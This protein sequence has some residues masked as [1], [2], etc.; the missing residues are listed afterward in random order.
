MVFKFEIGGARTGSYDFAD[1]DDDFI[2]IHHYLKWY[3]FGFTRSFDNLSIEIRNGRISRNEAITKLSQELSNRP[4]G[5]IEKFCDLVEI[6]K[7]DF[8]KIIERFRNS[9]IWTNKGNHWKIENFIIEDY[10]WK[11]EFDDSVLNI[12]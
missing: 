5:D 4:I 10:D 12:L 6:Q 1:I 9:K 8:F 11:R 7:S 3:K 2:S